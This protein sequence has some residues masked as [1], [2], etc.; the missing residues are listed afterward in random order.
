MT[1]GNRI[2]NR[3]EELK[4]TQQELAQRSRLSQ[5]YISKVEKDMFI[6]KA[7]TLLALALSLELPYTAFLKYSEERSD[8]EC[9]QK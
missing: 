3:R 2:I 1:L 7:T 6:P 5:G 9:L 4:L 8:I